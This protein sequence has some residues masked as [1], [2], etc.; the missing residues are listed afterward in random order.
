MTTG[1]LLSIG[2]ICVWTVVAVFVG[3]K[4]AQLVRDGDIIE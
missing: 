2:V 4:N 3:N 1:T